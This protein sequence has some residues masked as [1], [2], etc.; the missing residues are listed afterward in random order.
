MFKPTTPIHATA[1]APRALSRLTLC[2]LVC[3]RTCRLESL[4]F[5]FAPFSHSL[6]ICDNSTSSISMGI[7]HGPAKRSDRFSLHSIHVCVEMMDALCIL[8]PSGVSSVVVGKIDGKIRV[9][10]G[11]K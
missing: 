9:A 5:L 7:P 6:A 3:A 1:R 2:R 10:T 4:L 8:C 11:E